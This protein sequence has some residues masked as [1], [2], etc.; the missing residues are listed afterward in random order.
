MNIKNNVLEAV[1]H[2]PLIKLNKVVDAKAA[3][4]L[5]KCEFLNPTGSIKDRMA[6]HIL[7]E[8]EKSG[9]IKPGGT[10]V[11]NTSGNTGLGVAM[12]AA[13]KGY[14]CIFTMPDKMSTEKINMLKAFGAEVVITP[15]DVPGDSP[16]HYVNVAKRIAGETPNSFYVNQYHNPL[17]IDAHYYLT[18]PE[19]YEETDGQVD[20]IVAGAGT[21]GTVSGIGRFFKEKIAKTRIVGVDPLGSVH[22]H[23]FYTHTMP[24]P[25]V[26]KVEGVGEDILCGAM[27]FNAVDEFR[28]VNDKESFQMARRLVREEGL[29]CGGSSGS[30]AH[31]AVQIAREIGPGK[32][33]V[34]VLPDS[35]SRYITKFLADSWMKDFGFLESSK[36]HLGTVE[37]LLPMVKRKV[38]TAN[39]D[40]PLST[41]IARLKEH[42][43]SQL[44]VLNSQGRPISIIHESDL[45][46]GL[47]EGSVTLES[48]AKDVA[49][50]I[51]GLIYP[52]A[53]IEELFRIFETDRVAIVVDSNELVGIISK[54]D[55]IDY[56]SRRNPKG[57]G[58]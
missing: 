21:G 14:R 16:Q 53:Q 28:Q 15:T 49:H 42:G 24:T 34:V 47:Q 18:A 45:L 51:G 31:I 10:V 56:L 9:L 55:L 19:I 58:L 13:I 43:I 41:I 29:F 54:I 12:V 38:I 37:E 11:E 17:N 52:K 23:Y 36:L 35:G 3:T 30:A 25:H 20:V 27:D 5:A 57:A 1:G 22:Y 50:P 8:A 39:E 26:Y 40:E 44:P 33:V 7:N 4:V 2:T 48:R 6:L 32:T 46:H